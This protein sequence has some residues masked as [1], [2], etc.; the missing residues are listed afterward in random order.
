MVETVMEKTLEKAN[1]NK[2]NSFGCRLKKLLETLGLSQRKFAEEIGVKPPTISEYISGKTN[3]SPRTLKII[4]EKFNVNPEW[5]REGKGEMFLP[6]EEKKELDEKLLE[7]IIIGL[8]NAEK[9]LGKELKP[10]IKAKL[11]IYAYKHFKDKKDWDKALMELIE[12]AGG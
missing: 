9:K 7:N 8:E 2:E 12:I 3:P 5:L 1:D 11:I 10:E 6:Q 4:E